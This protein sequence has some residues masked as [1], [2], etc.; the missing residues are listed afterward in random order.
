MKNYR[1]IYMLESYSDEGDL[2]Y[3]LFAANKRTAERMAR[4]RKSSPAPT[5]R[6]LTKWERDFITGTVERI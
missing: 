5:I 6:R 4:A 2:I 1:V 3:R